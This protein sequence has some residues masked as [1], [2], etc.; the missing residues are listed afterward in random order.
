M[1]LQALQQQ[2][3]DTL[4]LT[5]RPV[6]S[7]AY[8]ATC[9]QDILNA[10]IA[11]AMR[12]LALNAPPELLD[13]ADSNP[14]QDTGFLVDGTITTAPTDSDQ[15]HV[16]IELTGNF[17]RLARV[18][19][20]NWH[21]AIREVIDDTSDKALMLK[22]LIAKAT[23][24][25]PVA[26]ISCKKKKVLSLYPANSSEINAID[27]TTVNIPDVVSSIG[28]ETSIPLPPKAIAPMIY[29]AAGFALASMRDNDAKNFFEIAASFL[30][31]QS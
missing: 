21:K 25:R 20:T 31:Y 5:I 16:T 15:G 13:G 1:T 3:L 2:I 19:L 6:Q 17:V 12:W 29:Q 22:D 10:A 23:N 24:D 7:S 18:K 26:V 4:D 8:A 28:T 14:A 11:N 30:K 9:R 27:I